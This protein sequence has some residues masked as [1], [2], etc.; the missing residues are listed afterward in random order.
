M[1]TLKPVR[2]RNVVIVDHYDSYTWNLAHLCA[3]VTGRLPRVV[4]HDQTN[5]SDL[6]QHSHILLSPGP[7]TPRDRGAFA[8]GPE[9]FE[10]VEVPVLGVCLG[11]QGLILAFGGSIKRV[12]PGHG[13]RATVTHT[14]SGLFAGVPQPFTAIRYHSLAADVVPDELAITSTDSRTGLVMSVQHAQR[15]LAGVQFHPESILSEH[16]EAVM[17]NFLS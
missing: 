5:L 3:A 11:M 6:A 8:L 16:G 13:V 7:G 14:G 9:F 4:Q 2:S 10:R 15:P 1:S 17:R 12:P